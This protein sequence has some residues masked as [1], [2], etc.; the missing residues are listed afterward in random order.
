MGLTLKQHNLHLSRRIKPQLSVTL[1]RNDRTMKENSLNSSKQA[2]SGLQQT[3]KEGFCP[4]IHRGKTGKGW[5]ENLTEMIIFPEHFY[6][7]EV[8]FAVVCF[9][10]VYSSTYTDGETCCKKSQI[11]GIY[12]SPRVKVY[13]SSTSAEFKITA[14]RL[15]TVFLLLQMKNIRKLGE[16]SASQFVLTA[17]CYL[18][19][20]FDRT[21][22]LYRCEMGERVT[23]LFMVAYALVMI[24]PGRCAYCSSPE[25]SEN[26]HEP[27]VPA[28]WLP[29]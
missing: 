19:C 10:S 21:D 22:I 15:T 3:S 17:Q 6:Q 5:K 13:P 18:Q 1:L 26:K 14:N 23:F 24:S 8:H 20:L 12:L 9:H 11:L 27:E 25:P 4:T 2:L 7:N 16:Y 29:Y 28:V